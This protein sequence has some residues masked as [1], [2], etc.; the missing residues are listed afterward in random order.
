MVNERS[1]H[2][3]PVLSVQPRHSLLHYMIRFNLILFYFNK[4]CIMRKYVKSNSIHI[5]LYETVKV[6]TLRFLHN[7]G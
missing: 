7:I 3:Q 5:S 2:A 6:L 1:A 4:L